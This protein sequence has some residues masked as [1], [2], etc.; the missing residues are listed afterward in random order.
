M[1]YRSPG[2]RGVLGLSLALV[3]A[4][5]AAGRGPVEA[6]NP[7][8]I[9]VGPQP[10]GPATEVTTFAKLNGRGKILEVGAI[11]PMEMVENPPGHGSGPAGAHAVVEFPEVV[12]EQ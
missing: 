1:K 3:A 4:V 7:R 8:L 10:G 9:V 12:Q 2:A 5:A 11:L 6:A